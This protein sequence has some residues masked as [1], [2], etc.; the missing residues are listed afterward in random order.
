M[1]TEVIKEGLALHKEKFKLITRGPT[2]CW[3]S[4]FIAVTFFEIFN[5]V[6]ENEA[7]TMPILIQIRT[8]LWVIMEE[9]YHW[10]QRCW[11]VNEL[12]K[13]MDLKEAPCGWSLVKTQ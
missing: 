2:K 10:G 11:D 4:S 8:L 6:P 9:F 7:N 12:G 1:L 5:W 3:D 13:F